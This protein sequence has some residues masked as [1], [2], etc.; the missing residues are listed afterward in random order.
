MKMNLTTDSLLNANEKSGH[1]VGF[2][3]NKGDPLTWKILTDE[4]QIITRS[5]VRSANKTSSLT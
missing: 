4:Q 5:A 3:D 2:A 1:W